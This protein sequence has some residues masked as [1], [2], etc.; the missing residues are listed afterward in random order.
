MGLFLVIVLLALSGWVVS[1]TFRRLR[2][3]RAGR[4]WWLAFCLLAAG[5]AV[6]GCRLAFRADYQVSSTT[7][8]VSFPVPLAFFRKEGDQWTD[9]ITPPFVLYPGLV[10]NA[11]S[12]VA[13]ALLP[14]LLASRSLERKQKVEDS[15]ISA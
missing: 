9:F 14:L 7:R 1:L 12:M 15:A 6:V 10:A 8:L 4:G 11:M 2:H 3:N 13:T 5:G